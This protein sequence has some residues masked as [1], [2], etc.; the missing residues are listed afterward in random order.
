MWDTQLVQESWRSGVGKDTT[1]L[2]SEV[3]S[4]NSSNSLIINI[5]YPVLPS[6]YSFPVKSNKNQK[7]T[8][9]ALL[10][11]LK[12]KELSKLYDENLVSQSGNT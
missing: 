10:E 8:W 3:L 11:D 7:H 2:G 5:R 1:H 12:L 9:L 4:K 6:M